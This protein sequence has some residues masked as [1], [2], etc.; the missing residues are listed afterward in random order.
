MAFAESGDA[1]SS[2]PLNVRALDEHDDLEAEVRHYRSRV[3]DLQGTVD[4]LRD[5]L[6]TQRSARELE[7]TTAEMQS[8]RRELTDE[9]HS[10]RRL[11]DT[12][13]QA[14]ESRSTLVAQLKEFEEAN[15]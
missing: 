10:E 9:A 12:S 11:R 13:V 8:V 1:G 15:R 6:E 2:A 14:A 3:E 4:G 7:R 5:E